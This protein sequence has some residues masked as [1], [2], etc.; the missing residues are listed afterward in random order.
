MTDDEYED[1]AQ[2]EHDKEI[3]HIADEHGIDIEDVEEVQSIADD[4]GV[5]FDDAVTI[6]NES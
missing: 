3:S 2:E 4:H 1:E 6:F 5:D